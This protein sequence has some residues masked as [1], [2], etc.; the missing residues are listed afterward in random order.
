LQEEGIEPADVEIEDKD[1][2]MALYEEVRAAR[3]TEWDQP[4]KWAQLV[5]Y[6]AC[7]IAV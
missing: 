7:A 4:L 1:V 2:A 6:S 5:H 3:E